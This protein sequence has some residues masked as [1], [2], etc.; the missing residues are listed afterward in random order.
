MANGQVFPLTFT[1]RTD[2]QMWRLLFSR[3]AIFAGVGRESLRPV[4]GNTNRSDLAIVFS[5][6]T[7]GADFDINLVVIGSPQH[8]SLLARSQAVGVLSRT[9][10]PGARYFG[11]Y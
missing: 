4:A 2:N 11:Y 9:R 3:D 6:A 7:A 1:M 5:R 10:N 8:A